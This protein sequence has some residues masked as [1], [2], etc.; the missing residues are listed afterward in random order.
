MPM[1]DEEYA[2]KLQE[3]V[4]Q[5][6]LQDSQ[7]VE[8]FSE[9]VKI[10]LDSSDIIKDTKEKL[11]GFLNN[12]AKLTKLEEKDIRMLMGQLDITFAWQMMS[13]PDYT[14]SFNDET[15]ISNARAR[16]FKMLKRAEGGF[17]RKMEASQIKISQSDQTQDDKKKKGFITGFFSRM[18]GKG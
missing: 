10:I 12:D 18:L 2:Q 16:Y 15:M 9:Y 5:D 7:Q 1:I 14:Y 8:G 13:R 17:E 3:S 11:W 4:Q 6:E